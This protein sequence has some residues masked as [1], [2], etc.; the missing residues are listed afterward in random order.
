[1]GAITQASS[2][3]VPVGQVISQNPAAGAQ[4]A[5]GSAVALT[6]STGPAPV[7]VPNVVGLTQAA[8]STAI[9]DVGL[10]VGAITQTASNTVPAGQVISQNPAAGA[11]VAPGSAV[12]L[13]VSTGP[14]PVAVPNVVG[15]SQAAASTS[16]TGS[17]LSVGAITQASSDT[18]PAG[19]VISQNPA[20]GAQVAPGSAVA[21]TVS[22]GPALVAV[23]NV[24]G[25]TQ[26]AASTS[27]TGSGLTVGAI[28]QA[29]SDTV[30]AGQVISQNPAAGAQ[31]APGSAVALTV[32]TGPA[33]VPVLDVT[34]QNRDVSSGPGSTTFFVM[35]AGDGSLLWEAM[36]IEGSDW[37]E[38]ATGQSGVD[39]GA[40][41][42]A[43]SENTTPDARLGTIRVTASAEGSPIDVTVMQG[44]PVVGEGQAEGTAEGEGTPPGIHTADQDGDAQIGLPELL[45]VI[46]IFNSRGYQCVMPPATSEDGY[47][48]GPGPDHECM[49]HASDYK[50]Q[51]WEIS[52]TELLRLIQFFNF[53]GYHDCAGLGTEDG[54]CPGA[55]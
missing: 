42:V 10:T 11:Q 15:L 23:P 8:A 9:T 44:V 45:R 43:F 47:L 30:P 25:L 52:L 18:V 53:Q 40:I 24:V 1:V 2:S 29:S 41:E 14:A 4:V 46:Q 19:Q 12:A 3:T 17:G 31:V 39:D 28:T 26:A 21:L 51:D 34:P 7:A 35:N 50:P 36:V 32:S 5:P 27:I 20:A 48:P 33:P 16:I 13:T 54:F 6:V 55:A 38:I 49:P 37:L 22:T